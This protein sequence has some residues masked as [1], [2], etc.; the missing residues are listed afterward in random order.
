MKEI[1]ERLLKIENGFKPIE[2]EAKKIVVSKP[3]SDSMKLAVEL[4]ENEFYQ[5]RS[6]AVFLL[7]YI[8]SKDPV[9][10]QIL[11]IKVSNDKSWQVQEIL[12][13]S[14]D[15]YCMDTGYEKSLPVIK[16]WL[17]DK[18]PNVCRAVTEG[19]RIWTGRPFFKTNPQVA[20]Q[21]IS[22]HK[23]HES[24]YLRRSVGNALRDI[25][26][27]HKALVDKEIS[28]WDLS[29]ELIRFTYKFVTKSK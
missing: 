3:I 16:D 27:K 28:T 26:K 20:I 5:V 12:A 19:L 15:Q 6:L 23:A 21:L 29:N 10:L 17:S 9:A 22:Q 7:G 4:L 11:R 8:S 1:I 14:F 18:I 25:S 24:E 2:F 13:K